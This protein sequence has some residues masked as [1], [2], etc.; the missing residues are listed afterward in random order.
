MN[1]RDFVVDQEQ[2]EFNVLEYLGLLRKHLKVI[3]LFGVAGFAAGFLYWFITPPKYRAAVILKMSHMSRD[4]IGFGQQ[5]VWDPYR[6]EFFKTEFQ[7]IES[8]PVAER[9]VRELG[10][11]YFTDEADVAKDG[12]NLTTLITDEL[13]EAEEKDAQTRRAQEITSLARGLV[14][15]VAANSV[16]GTNL[17]QVSF[18]AR[19]AERAQTI[20]N[21]WA[22]AYIA[23]DLDVNYEKNLEAYTFISNKSDD[24]RSKV[25]R[26]VAEVNRLKQEKDIVSIGRSNTTMEEDAL[27]RLNDLMLE[28]ESELAQKMTYKETLVKSGH[29]QSSAVNQE[30]VVKDLVTRL[31][32]ERSKY[33]QDLKIYKPQAPVMESRANQISAMERELDK[34]RRKVHEQLVTAAQAEIAAKESELE[35]I[36]GNFERQKRISTETKVVAQSQIDDLDSQISVMRK[37][38]EMLDFKR[39]E[40]DLALSLKNIGRSD[41]V[42]MQEATKPGGPFAPSLKRFSMAGVVIGLLIAA[43]LIFILEVTDRKIHTAE[44]LERISGVPSLATI[45]RIESDTKIKKGA[46]DN[47]EDR[48]KIAFLTHSNPTCAFAENYR[49]LRTNIQLSKAERNQVILVTSAMSGDGKTISSTN[50]AISIAQLD[51]KVLLVDCDL[52]RPKMHKIFRTSDQRGVVTMIVDRDPVTKSAH[53]TAIP[54]LDVLPAGPIAPN[55][56]ELV[57]S[58]RMAEVVDEWRKAYDF[59]VMD[60]SPILAVTDASILAHQVDSVIFVAKASVTIRDDAARATQILAQNGIRALGTILNGYDYNM[61][62]KYGYK[63]GYRR[64]GYGYGYGPY[65]YKAEKV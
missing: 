22:K 52:R 20:A 51:R 40:L 3:V 16:R 46:T 42:I 9:V 13:S 1:N 31:S 47:H 19:D 15:S 29:T 25:D 12:E 64:Y 38:L 11:A 21:T 57:A 44:M 5:F 8:I 58:P 63:Y 32:Q 14:G 55:P 43:G 37:Q 45:P 61:G 39:E 28:I 41:K 4:V 6:E 2:V 23:H 27:S 26:M 34:Q 59:I 48:A 49:H 54:N 17:V 35:R 62:R 36:K 65:E 56:A 53:H 30:P 33:E 24:L 10:L 60:S 18:T 7:I 50:L